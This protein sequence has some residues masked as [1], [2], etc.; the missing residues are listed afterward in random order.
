MNPISSPKTFLCITA[1][2]VVALTGA[3]HAEHHLAQESANYASP[4][5]R[6]KPLLTAEFVFQP[7]VF[8]GN[9]FPKC[10]FTSTDQAKTLLGDYKV[11]V[12]F[13][14]K[15]YEIVD[16]PTDTGR[17][18]AIVTITAEDGLEYVRFRTLYKTPDRLSLRFSP[19]DGEL[20]F[21]DVIGVE[22]EVWSNQARSA[23]DYLAAAIT[24]DMQRSHDFA[25][26]L[27]GLDETGPNQ[28]PV[29][30]RESAV[31]KDRE[32]W[33]KL[34]RELNGNAKRFQKPIKAPVKVR[35]LDAPVLRAGTEA[36]AGMK[37]G[38]TKKLK[39]LLQEW[40]DNSDQ[41][42]NVTVARHGVVFLNEAYGSRNGVETTPDTKFIVYSIS[43]ALSGSLL[44][45]FVD[46]G[47]ISLD[48]PVEKI[49]P[50]F[51]QEGV[52]TPA[53]FHHLFTHTADMD[54]H[55]TDP[56]SDLEHVYGEAYP[57]LG[58][59]KQHR[60]NGS[61]IAIGLKALEQ[62]SGYSLPNLYQE[63]LFGP[64]GC[65]SIES[66]DGSAMTWSNAYDLARVGQMLANHGAY[67]NKRFFSE[68]TFEQMLPQKLDKLLSPD[69]D[70][71]W[72][73]GLVWY[74]DHGFSDKTI[75]HGSYS[76]CTLRVDLE[77]DLVITMSR[78]TAGKNFNE[79]HPKFIETITSGVED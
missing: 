79:Y 34:K 70:V 40:S 13:Y 43:K 2:F 14:S 67:G 11:D 9:R 25:I 64:L 51:R 39:A 33:L 62:I 30:K 29:T 31:T 8:S 56:W 4:A 35:G 7:S 23:N 16:K 19:L 72:G 1:L 47:V 66:I 22:D 48:D 10:D 53:T 55:Y 26:L 74:R 3:A 54:D 76:S 69:T 65:D 28:D 5:D 32:W 46:N 37:P 52:E 50:E 15:E 36:E 60:Y 41:P 71:T 73:I 24:R 18:G 17:Y 77:K 63:Y 27:A 59:G 20:A 12:T 61:S 58:I 78:P 75:G 49:L 6:A 68:E 44:M 21:P 57:Y 42:F 45:T 38:T